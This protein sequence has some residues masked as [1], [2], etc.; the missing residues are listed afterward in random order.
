MTSSRQQ[1]IGK[2]FRKPGSPQSLCSQNTKLAKAVIKFQNVRLDE[3]DKKEWLLRGR[4]AVVLQDPCG[5]SSLEKEGR[6]SEAP[7]DSSWHPQ[8]RGELLG[9]HPAKCSESCLQPRQCRLWRFASSSWTR[10]L[11]ASRMAGSSGV[12]A[13]TS[14]LTLP[15]S[16]P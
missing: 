3:W 1:H 14:S 16:S 15:G 5:Y 4:S 7:M 12:C 13:D 6:I 10:N 9:Q 2:G 8:T 11:R